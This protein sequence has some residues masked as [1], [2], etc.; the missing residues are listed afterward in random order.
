MYYSNAEIN[1]MAKSHMSD[2]Y[3]S[4]KMCKVSK[5]KQSSSTHSFFNLLLVVK[6]A[7]LIKTKL[8]L[9]ICY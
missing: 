3:K 6:L 1:L 7:Q 2:I 8:V 5:V 9:Y 4:C